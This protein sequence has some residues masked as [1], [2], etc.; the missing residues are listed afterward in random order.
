MYLYNEKKSVFIDCIDE[1]NNNPCMLEIRHDAFLRI[2]RTINHPKL[3]QKIILWY[4]KFFLKQ[5]QQKLTIE[6]DKRKY[7]I[8]TNDK[9]GG[10]LNENTDFLLQRCYWNSI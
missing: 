3:F 6:L 9:Y 1:T 7:S 2:K 4:Q 10:I 5:T 8:F